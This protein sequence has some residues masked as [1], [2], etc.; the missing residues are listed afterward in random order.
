MVLDL[1]TSVIYKDVS[2]I[3]I[4]KV[5]HLLQRSYRGRILLR[6]DVVPV[7]NPLRCFLRRFIRVIISEQWL[8]TT[9]SLT[10]GHLRREK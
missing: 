3:E 2:F 4:R 7:F 10:D 9:L 5:L 1:F 6:C 8:Q